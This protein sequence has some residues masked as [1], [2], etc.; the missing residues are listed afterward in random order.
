MSRLR[1]DACRRSLTPR[2]LHRSDEPQRARHASST[3]RRS[4]RDSLLLSPAATQSL[5]LATAV[6]RH[7]LRWVHASGGLYFDPQPS[8]SLVLAGRRTAPAQTGAVISPQGECRFRLKLS[9]DSDWLRGNR[10][11]GTTLQVGAAGL[12]NVD[13]AL[14]ERAIFN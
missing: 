8:A 1:S 7:R 6:A 3:L 14:E 9:V 2:T 13:A 11:R 12:A 4:L 5:S 10:G